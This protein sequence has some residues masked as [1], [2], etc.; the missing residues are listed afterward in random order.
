MVEAAVEVDLAFDMEEMSEAET[1]VTS[2]AEELKVLAAESERPRGMSVFDTARPFKAEGRPEE[3]SCCDCFHC[4][5]GLMVGP[6]PNQLGLSEAILD[7]TCAWPTCVWCR[8]ET[9]GWKLGRGGHIEKQ[10][11][12]CGDF[13]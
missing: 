7:F 5:Y 4:A 2:W 12:T 1:A 11:L 6:V 9:R 3:A 8:M 10:C 13:K